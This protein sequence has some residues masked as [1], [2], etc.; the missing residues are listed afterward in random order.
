MR[1]AISLLLL[2]IAA[3]AAAPIPRKAGEFII[4]MP[5]GKQTLLSSYKGKTIVLAMM[6]TT[7]PHCQKVAQ[8]LSAVQKEYA[9][10]GVQVLGATFDPNAATQ[11]KQFDAVF[12][13]GFPC[14]YSTNEAVLAFLVHPVDNPPFVPILV[15]IDKTGTIRS[16]H[17]VTAETPE[18]GVE[19]N[20]FA[21][22]DV[23]IRQELDKVLKAS[24][25]KS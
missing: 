6:F 4:H 20:F 21:T 10:K 11:V 22:P 8:I 14:G 15:F 19:H 16:L 17:M 5:D 2:S 24:A 9:D 7:C 23:S 18:A 25:P 1:K 3:F 13:K 12:A